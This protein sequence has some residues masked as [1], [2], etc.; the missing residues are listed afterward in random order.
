MSRHAAGRRPRSAWLTAWQLAQHARNVAAWLRACRRP[1]PRA[2]A[3]YVLAVLA[4]YVVAVL[5]VLDLAMLIS[6]GK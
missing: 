5:A 1:I 2:I 4:Y 3:C 6:G